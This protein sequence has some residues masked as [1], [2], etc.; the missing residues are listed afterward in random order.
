MLL[1]LV[2]I[3]GAEF[4]GHSGANLIRALIAAAYLVVGITCII[5][6][7]SHQEPYLRLTGIAVLCL[8]ALV[9]WLGALKRYRAIADTPTA[10][11]RSAP[12]GY[13][14]LTG[15]CRSAP[16]E[17]LLRYGKIPP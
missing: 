11:L 6:S 17:E 5:Y 15:K 16:D 12:Q 4:R 9:A 13:V 3:G 8:G 10:V 7:Y 14:E 2:H 1:N